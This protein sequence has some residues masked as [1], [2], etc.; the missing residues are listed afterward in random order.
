MALVVGITMIG[1]ELVAIG[2]GVTYVVW[3]GTQE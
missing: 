1:I 3:L 2:I